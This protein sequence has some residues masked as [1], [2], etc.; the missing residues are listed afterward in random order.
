MFKTI[1]QISNI[2]FSTS[3]NA[4]LY[5]LKKIPLIK[6]LFKNSNYSFFKLKNALSTL[7]LIYKL[8]STPF[9]SALIFLL[10]MFLPVFIVFDGEVDINKI[11]VLIFSFYILFPFVLS[12][13]LS[14]DRESFIIVKQLKMH[15]RNY[16]L[17]KL[18]FGE[19]LNFFSKALLFSIFFS[20]LSLNFLFGIKVALI[21]SSANMISEA[22]YLYFF[23][24]KDLNK[25]ESE[26]ARD[27]ITVVAYSVIMVLT[28]VI[29]LVL[30][31][32]IYF[33]FISFFFNSSLIFI[34]LLILASLSITYLYKYNN[35][36]NVINYKNTIEDFK[37]IN[38]AISEANFANVKLKEKNYSDED[39]H[40]SKFNDKEGY[41]YLNALFFERHKRIIYKPMII[42]SSIIVAV[43]IIIFLVNLFIEAAVGEELIDYIVN[44]YTIF[45]FFIYLLSNSD[46]IVK[47]L[48][49]NCD[50]S[51]LRYGFYKQ[52][53]AL[54]KTFFLRLKKI[55]F[56]NIIPILILCICLIIITLIYS[57]SN[58][59]NL[60]PVL[61]F[62]IVLSL[63]FSV[64]YIF[65]YY[66]F[67]PYTTDLKVKNPFFSIINFLV[68]FISY[69]SLQITAPAKIFLPI[70]I[71]IAIVYILIAITLVYKKAPKTFRVK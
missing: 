70:T 16:F 27:I 21:I 13:I 57:P 1:V 48:F 71:V 32:E 65:M 24:K 12:K 56:S 36:W 19:I 59:I 4:F 22:I 55:V 28:Y 23:A 2:Q 40:T 7:S 54:L 44:G 64:H 49:Y 51:L 67:Q 6:R 66:I 9:K 15:P 31:I 58:I 69:M 45:T 52:G 53:D 34:V 63:F 25:K 20:F 38:Q 39:L 26:N 30:Q 33:N 37:K 11:L 8:I 50:K 35:F 43:F 60:I 17:S 14:T 68:Y 61:L 3:I 5:F 42:K 41:D 47:S 10:T 29:A 62:I 18:F 46:T